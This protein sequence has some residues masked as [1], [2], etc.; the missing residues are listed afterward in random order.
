[1]EAV[2][3]REGPLQVVQQQ[4][5]AARDD[6]RE[7]SGPGGRRR[8]VRPPDLGR[9]LAYAVDLARHG[10][11]RRRDLG[12][13]GRFHPAPR[14]LEPHDLR[15]ERQPRLH[16][17][18][19]ALLAVEHGALVARFVVQQHVVDASFLGERVEVDGAEARA[20]VVVEGAHPIAPRRRVL[21]VV[22]PQQRR[23]VERVAT[24][25]VLQLATGRGGLRLRCGAR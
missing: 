20:P 23:A 14:F 12:R 13:I 16:L 21:D 2:P 10:G 9:A 11:Q 8:A 18:E 17:L 15:S 4:G 7:P 19:A 1:M 3:V 22:A 6:A 5:G 25:G 24:D